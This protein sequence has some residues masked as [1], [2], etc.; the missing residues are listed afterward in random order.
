MESEAIGEPAIRVKRWSECTATER[1]AFV[2]SVAEGGAVQLHFIKMGVENAE[3]LVFAYRADQ[4][5]GTA[6]LKRPK[7]GYRAGV[8]A[9]AK[10]NK[11]PEDYPYEVGYVWVHESQ[12]GR[13]LSLKLLIHAMS[14]NSHD[15]MYATTGDPAM[16]K[17]LEKAG[18]SETGSPYPGQNGPLRL[19]TYTRGV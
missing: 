11:T 12:R 5:V 1:E 19:F 18:F 4:L 16:T 9:S 8:F 3:R 7:E 10:A 15:R 6:A 14:A 2:D 13:S 17:S